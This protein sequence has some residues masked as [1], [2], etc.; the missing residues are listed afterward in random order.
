MSTADVL[1]GAPPSAPPAQPVSVGDPL[2]EWLARTGHAGAFER[3]LALATEVFPK[4]TTFECSLEMHDGNY[5]V[6]ECVATV[7]VG[8]DAY[9]YYRRFV[10]RWIYYPQADID[11]PLALAFRERDQ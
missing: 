4:G 11:A 1:V 10:D 7:P 5:Q 3:F 8:N 9:T 6:V 2:A